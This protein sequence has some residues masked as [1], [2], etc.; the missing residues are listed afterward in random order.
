M[1]ES[2]DRLGN[3]CRSI[4]IKPHYRVREWSKFEQRVYFLLSIRSENVE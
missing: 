2:F 1:Y 4:K 3:R